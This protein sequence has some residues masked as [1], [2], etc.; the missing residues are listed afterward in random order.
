LVFVQPAGEIEGNILGF[1]T[2]ML[3]FKSWNADSN[4]KAFG[5]IFNA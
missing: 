2:G 5:G 1:I 4:G 3:V